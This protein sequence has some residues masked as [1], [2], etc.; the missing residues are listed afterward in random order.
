VYA[1]PARGWEL[2]FRNVTAREIISPRRKSGGSF[3]YVTFRALS[4]GFIPRRTRDAIRTRYDLAKIGRPRS[5][6]EITVHETPSDQL[7][8]AFP[9][10]PARNAESS[11]WR[12][13][14]MRRPSIPFT[15]GIVLGLKPRA[16]KSFFIRQ[17]YF[18]IVRA[19][20]ALTASASASA[21]LYARANRSLYRGS[22][23]KYSQ[24]R[25]CTV[26]LARRRPGRVR[27]GCDGGVRVRET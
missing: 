11:S 8:P 26:P 23:S 16:N 18:L 20:R 12:S 14:E 21:I 22:A 7:K 15:A 27:R 10:F 17:R 1:L 9:R 4:S 5:R 2:Q 3:P 6:N 19:R 25:P 24:V 13:L